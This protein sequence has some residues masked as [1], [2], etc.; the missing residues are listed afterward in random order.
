MTKAEIPRE[1]VS[2]G[3]ETNTVN[4]NLPLKNLLLKLFQRSKERA[5]MNIWI[6]HLTW[7]R[8]NHTWIGWQRSIL[9]MHHYGDSFRNQGQ[10]RLGRR[11]DDS[12]LRGFCYTPA[13]KC[14]VVERLIA[15]GAIP[16][17]KTNLDNSR[18]VLSV[19]GVPTGKRTTRFDPK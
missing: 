13:E 1:L 10:Y 7:K 4:K 17:G 15:A 3:C 11:A 8:L 5:D 18:R 2:H 12:G 6:H 19:R 14:G 16:L 9:R